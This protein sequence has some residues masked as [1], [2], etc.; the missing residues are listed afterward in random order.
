MTTLSKS[1]RVQ[2]GS[3]LTVGYPRIRD[4]VTSSGWPTSINRGASVTMPVGGPG[5]G[6]SQPVREIHG[7][8]SVEEAIASAVNEIK[9]DI[10]LKMAPINSIHGNSNESTAVIQQIGRDVANLQL[11]IDNI[12]SDFRRVSHAQEGVKETN[13]KTMKKIESLYN[14]TD[15]MED[16]CQQFYDRMSTME[17]KLLS[18]ILEQDSKITSI[19]RKQEQR[20]KSSRRMT[21]HDRREED[22]D[23]DFSRLFQSSL[24]T[25]ATIPKGAKLKEPEAFNGT[26][27]TEA[28]TFI[29]KMEMYFE[30]Y[31]GS[32]SDERKISS[33]LSNMGKGE[34]TT[35]ANPLM[36]KHLRDEPHQY[37]TSWKTFKEA[38]LLNF[39]DP[40][41][42]DK[43][44]KDIRNLRQTGPAQ[45]YASQ[46]RLLKEDL[47]WDDQAL[48]DTFKKGLRTKLQSELLYIKI[49]NPE[50]DN[51]SLE[52]WIELT[53]RTDDILQ[54]AE[55]IGTTPE[56]ESITMD[57]SGNCKPKE[58]FPDEV[59]WKRKQEGK[60]QKCGSKGHMMRNC[61]S[62]A[63]IPDPVLEQ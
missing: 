35:W 25:R 32:F 18:A 21:N 14:K 58:R 11:L 15:V 54:Q 59:F 38:F 20:S 27:G 9:D 33:T 30:E 28:E 12:R 5:I 50:I 56:I 49:T 2:R 4:H 8:P 6:S 47:D 45:T 57:E 23:L 37:L 29:M 55:A 51:Y 36:Q 43:A 60:C 3:E 42:K 1:A 7:P 61:P 39:S 13:T 24:E 16:L 41:K 22:G 44:I 40:S 31:P 19:M 10:S 34:P 17:E 48:I 46:F 53:I 26:R 62:E 63:Y 52:Q